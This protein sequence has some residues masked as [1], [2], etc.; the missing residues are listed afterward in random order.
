VNYSTEFSSLKEKVPDEEWTRLELSAC[1]RLVDKYGM[2]GIEP[3]RGQP[4]EPV[5][6]SR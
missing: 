6:D 2:T 5:G 1:C 4:R 3:A